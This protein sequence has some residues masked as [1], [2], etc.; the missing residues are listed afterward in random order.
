MEPNEEFIWIATYGDQKSG[1]RMHFGKSIDDPIPFILTVT[2]RYVA[3]QNANDPS[4]KNS[5][6]AALLQGKT[7]GP[8]EDCI[9][10]QEARLECRGSHVGSHL[11]AQLER[12]ADAA[13]EAPIRLTG[14]VTLVVDE[15]T[16]GGASCRHWTH[17]CSR[18]VRCGWF[19]WGLTMATSVA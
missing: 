10:L 16:G 4:S 3:H 12:T 13:D 8:K 11:A 2:P 7:R 19:L 9:K 14:P 17:L 6:V 5:G 1:M 15:Q 18:P